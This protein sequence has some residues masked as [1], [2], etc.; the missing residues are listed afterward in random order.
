MIPW[1]ANLFKSGESGCQ[2]GPENLRQISAFLDEDS[3]KSQPRDGA[4]NAAKSCGGDGE[5]RE[6][7]VL[8]RIEAERYD[9]STR[10]KS[11]D[12]LFRYTE[13]PHVAVILRADRQWNIEVG[14]KTG[15]HA[16][17]VSIAPDE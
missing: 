11:T 17:L 12:G 9:Q 8:R 2:I 10:R 16:A 7:I 13:R 4:A 1:L 3:W 6:R 5:T 15:A 14:A